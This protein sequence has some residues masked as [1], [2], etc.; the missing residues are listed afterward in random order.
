MTIKAF[1][2]HIEL[3]NPWF[4]IGGVSGGCVLILIALITGCICYNYKRNLKNRTKSK[5]EQRFQ[6]EKQ[7]LLSEKSDR[8]PLISP[9]A[10]FDEFLQ[11]VE[12]QQQAEELRSM[13]IPSE[14]IQRTGEKLGKG[15]FG[16]ASVAIFMNRKVCVKTHH[17]EW[18]VFPS[19]NASVQYGTYG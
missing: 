8:P 3:H 16:V 1:K 5:Y 2:G 12:N 4:L 7:K 6:S 13:F 14:D 10:K 11:N 18:D 9:Q 19:S 15:Q 17:I